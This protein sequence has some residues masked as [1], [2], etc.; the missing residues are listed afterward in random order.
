MS[1]RVEK[2]IQQLERLPALPDAARSV[3]G[4]S[5]GNDG[6]IAAIT[7]DP[8]LA[9]RAAALL[10]CTDINDAM[11]RRGFAAVR[12]ATLTAAVVGNLGNSDTAKTLWQ[13]SLAVACAA[14]KLAEKL[15]DIDTA[16][17]FLAGALHDLGKLA[18]EKLLPKA[19]QRVIEATELARTDIAEI[20]HKI[21]GLDHHDLGKRLAE[22]WQ[23]PAAVR[24][25]AWLHNNDATGDLKVLDDQTDHAPL[26]RLITLADRIV[27]D[28]HLGYSGNHDF[29]TK[30]RA[31]LAAAHIPEADADALALELLEVIGD[32]AAA[33]GI[34]DNTDGDLY[35]RALLR[36]N[37][38]LGHV[39]DQ[40]A[41]R[42][43]K[44]S[45][46]TTYFEA[47]AAFNDKLIPDAPRHTVLKAIGA[48]ASQLIGCDTAAAFTVCPGYSTGDVLLLD[49]AGD[50]LQTNTLHVPAGDESPYPA[51]PDEDLKQGAPPILSVGDE[52]EWALAP[53]SPRLGGPGR[54]WVPLVAEGQVVGG[55]VWGAGDDEADRLAALSDEVRG[56]AQTFA[57][58]L[59]MA[60]V[61]D[62]AR[63]ASE[64][65]AETARRLQNAQDDALRAKTLMA[66]GQVAAGAAHEMNNPLMVISGRSQLLFQQLKTRDPNNAVKAKLI[67]EQSQKLSEMISQLMEFAQ[68]PKATRQATSVGDLLKLAFAATQ[69]LIEAGLWQKRTVDTALGEVPAV[70]VD[71]HHI[72]DAVAEVLANALQHTP[73][74][75][76]VTVT[77]SHD[78]ASERVIL[79]IADNGSGMSEQVKQHA[80]DPFFSA[81]PAGRRRGMGLAK[82]LRRVDAIGGWLKIESRPDQG[83]RVSILLPATDEPA[84]A[85]EAMAKAG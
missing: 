56:L 41:S 48:A 28:Q 11:V 66:L 64:Q 31:L 73:D 70:N 57:I 69:P 53:V 38:E 79:A 21:L 75:G 13:H 20:E 37:D 81:K 45:A 6:V 26:I 9:D 27:R 85:V 40:L 58:A 51:L 80:C 14:E 62:E 55:L 82:A 7:A 22:H 67:F 24:D 36:A 17:A 60:Q 39:S 76:T 23:M 15:P 2:I 77:A 63:D 3:L 25:A 68:P 74:G 52:L 47:L 34:D 54:W 71:P 32:R 83:T 59:R 61:R 4:A 12:A 49:R 84:I 46:R 16:D 65:L 10:G 78:A 29:T 35:Q 30:R 5:D 19:Y 50:T 8:E 42:N 18:L 44:L 43:Q 1:E 72:A 33:L